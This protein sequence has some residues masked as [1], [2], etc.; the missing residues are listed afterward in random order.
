MTLLPYMVINLALIESK[1]ESYNAYLDRY[2]YYD[3]FTRYLEVDKEKFT[4]N[5]C[6]LLAQ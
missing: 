5:S 4:K 6:Y 3:V 1:V 2:N